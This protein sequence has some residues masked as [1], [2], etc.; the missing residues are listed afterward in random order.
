MPGINDYLVGRIN[1]FFQSGSGP[2]HSKLSQVFSEIGVDDGYHFSPD[3]DSPTKQTRILDAFRKLERKLEQS[4]LLLSKLVN[5]L[6]LN[7]DLTLISNSKRNG[8][9]EALNENGWT[10]SDSNSL[11]TSVPVNLATAGRDSLQEQLN[12]LNRSTDDPALLLGTAKELIEAIYKFVLEEIG[13]GVPKN[14]KF[15][16]LQYLALDRL[17]MLPDNVDATKPGGAQ[18]RAI[19]QGA[20]DLAQQINELR[21]LQGTGHGRTL[22]TG[23]TKEAAM[24][25]IRQGG[26]LAEMLLVQLDISTGRAKVR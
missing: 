5:L 7:G 3:G 15:Q 13:T 10:L 24:F 23:V 25:V 16:Q 14:Y 1:D 20:R 8:L 2:T 6:R 18:L 12:R 19:D 4:A 21:N 22:P 11:E 26:L 9:V 17:Q